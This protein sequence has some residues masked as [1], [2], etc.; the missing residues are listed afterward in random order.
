LRLE[1]AELEELFAEMDA[2]EAAK[3]KQQQQQQ[4]QQQ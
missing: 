1:A 2:A 4:Q 3:K